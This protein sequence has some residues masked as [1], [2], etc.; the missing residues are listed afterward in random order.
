[1]ARL[2]KA[3]KE[4]ILYNALK[5]AG[6]FERE[7][8]IKLRSANLAES[9]RIH[10]IG[11]YE[12]EKKIIKLES[13]IS[14]LIE[15]IPDCVSTRGYF[16]LNKSYGLKASFG[17]MQTAIY[18]SGGND[19]N[20]DKRVQKQPSPSLYHDCIKFDVEHKLTKE[21]HS[22]ED[23][24]KVVSDLRTSVTLN[25]NA[26]TNSVTTDKKLIEVW[27]ESQELIPVDIERPTVNLPTT[28]VQSL[29]AMIGIPSEG[30]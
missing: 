15:S 27:P 25:V 21:F 26:M 6:V 4:K 8:E 13:K 7:A 2:T 3:I 10:A 24:R 18:Y 14:K 1:M 5:K 23:E 11:G 12:E 16:S 9:I 20:D 17:G 22:I 30:K 29:N 19:D 28:D